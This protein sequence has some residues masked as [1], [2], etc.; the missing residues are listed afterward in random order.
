M[1]KKDN[2]D[3]KN[4]TKQTKQMK[5]TKQTKQTKYE[6][7]DYRQ[8]QFKIRDTLLYGLFG[9][10]SAGMLGYIFYQSVIAM[11]L[12][13]FFLPYYFKEKK[14][15]LC[16]KQQEQLNEQFKETI[17]AVSA[18][19]SAGYS[20]ENAFR[21]AYADIG[22][23]YGEESLMGQELYYLSKG[24][25]NNVILERLLSDLAVRS[26]LDSIKDFAEI[27]CI[28]KRNGG[29]MNDM[30]HSCVAVICGKLEVKKEIQ[31]M[32][33]AK[34]YEQKIMNIVPLAII[35]YIGKTSPGFFDPLY[36]NWLGILIMTACVVI[37]AAAYLMAKKITAIEI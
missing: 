12:F 5:Q 17:L 35:L 2:D 18:G 29:D 13:L 7:Q 21:E 4:K 27:F 11:I 10:L 15:E 14:E 25:D 36:H 8:Y 24:L 3:R 20:V 23:V 37:Y 19:L 32:I 22:M 30:I 31:M 6:M 28:A 9:V 34:Q 26:G 1:M 16:R 33:H